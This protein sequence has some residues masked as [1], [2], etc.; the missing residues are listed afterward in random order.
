MKNIIAFLLLALI[1]ISST[2]TVWAGNF[3]SSEVSKLEKN[4]IVTNDYF[5]LGEKVILSGTVDNDAYLAGGNIIVDGHIKG[6]LMAIGGNIAISGQVD[7]DVRVI[8]G[9]ITVSGSIGG[10]LTIVAGS[11]TLGESANILGNLASLAGDLEITS[12]VNGKTNLAAGAVILGNEIGSDINM[13]VGDLTLTSQAY[14][15]GNLVYWSD[16]VADISKDASIS[17]TLTR[18]IPQVSQIDNKDIEESLA[19]VRSGFSIY[20]FITSLLLGLAILY[21]V[22][23][24]GINASLTIAKRPFLTFGV[25]LLVLIL[26]P[27]ISIF[28]I[29]TLVGLPI[30]LLL[31]AAFVFMLF[32]AKVFTALFVGLKILSLMRHKSNNYLSFVLGLLV[33]YIVGLTPYIGWIISSIV[34]L[35]GLGSF[36]ITKVNVYKN[37]RSKN[38]V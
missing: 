4:E 21:F 2:T 9:N 28:L 32:F 29:V 19:G 5:S 33:V 14:V 8:G 13:V 1:F 15:R 23:N 10:N 17:G 30:G 37:F 36:L 24:F 26:T 35:L 34:T 6:D 11:A 3:Q 38:L 12:P 22:P 7:G 20:S 25:G 27:L 16:K 31:L 18:N